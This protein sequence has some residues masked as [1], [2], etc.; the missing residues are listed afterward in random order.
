MANQD[1]EIISVGITRKTIELLA[2]DLGI[3]IE[4]AMRR[5]QSWSRRIRADASDFMY[6]QI[7]DVIQDDHI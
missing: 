5:V 6:A 7:G 1:D 3:D 4:T 2:E